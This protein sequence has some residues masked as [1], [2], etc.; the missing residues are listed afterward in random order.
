MIR[1]D[2]LCYFG[3]VFFTMTGM[4]SFTVIACLVEPESNAMAGPSGCGIICVFYYFFHALLWLL[5]GLLTTIFYYFRYS[6]TQINDDNDRIRSLVGYGIGGLL[7]IS[8]VV[9]S[10][11]MSIWLSATGLSLVVNIVPAVLCMA[12]SLL[13][14][15]RT[16]RGFKVLTQASVHR[17]NIFHPTLR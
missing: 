17:G 3:P 9:I 1:R 16:R 2:V 6:G 4:S 8:S 10:N 12:T 7:I 15:F 14:T 5:V 11:D 13:A